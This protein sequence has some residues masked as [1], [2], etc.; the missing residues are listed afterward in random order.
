MSIYAD[1]YIVDELTGEKKLVKHLNKA[2][3]DR[4][5]WNSTPGGWNK[6][7]KKKRA[8][9]TQ[10]D[11]RN[12]NK[13]LISKSIEGDNY[14]EPYDRFGAFVKNYNAVDRRKGWDER[15]IKEKGEA[16]EALENFKT[17]NKEKLDQILPI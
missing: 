12:L 5:K 17:E 3:I 2:R 11:R 14:K 7:G 6:S 10:P 1:N 8:R 13:H 15:N 4:G 16:V 9:F